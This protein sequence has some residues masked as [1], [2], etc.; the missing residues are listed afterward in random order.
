MIEKEKRV[1]DLETWF[2]E[3]LDNFRKEFEMLD[4]SEKSQI[5]KNLD[6]SY[7]SQIEIFWVTEPIEYQLFIT[8]HDHSRKDGEIIINGPFIGSELI[9][10][11]IEIMEEPRWKK[12]APNKIDETTFLR[13]DDDIGNQENKYSDLFLLHISN[14][15]ITMRN[16]PTGN[17]KKG[18]V[19]GQ[20]FDYDGWGMNIKGNIAELLKPDSLVSKSIKEAKQRAAQIKETK[21]VEIQQINSKN[22]EK[23]YLSVFGAYYYPGVRIGDNLELTFKEKLINTIGKPI[24]FP[25]AENKFTFNNKHGFFDTFGFVGIQNKSEKAA[26]KVLNTIFGVS[27]ILGYNSTSVRELE[28]FSMKMDSESLSIGGFSWQPEADRFSPYTSH[29]LRKIALPL[30]SMK[31]IINTAEKVSHNEPINESV[32]FLLESFTHF[33]NS[34]YSQSF[35]F[36]WLVIENY[37][38]RLFE[39]MLSEKEVSG[40]RKEKFKTQDKWSTETKIEVLNFNDIINLD[41]YNI[42]IRFNAK[43]NKFAH[44]G[45][46]I[47]KKESKELFEFSQNIIKNLLIEHGLADSEKGGTISN[48]IY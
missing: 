1:Q 39:E 6:F 37:I 47:D 29:G 31:M 15:I 22:D 16:D 11:V 44:K 3:L 46:T 34:E 45:I 25:E 5:P 7:P 9:P 42:F 18:N 36:S 14:L 48:H 30:D 24:Y 40:K 4:E 38:L 27:L 26:I 21:D 20:I 8:M 32:S 43:R 17:F 23:E 35:L 10:K 2:H 33:Y 13:F 28:L 19:S 41:E 12:D